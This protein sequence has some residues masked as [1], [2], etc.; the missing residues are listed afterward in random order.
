MRKSTPSRNHVDHDAVAAI[1]QLRPYLFSIAYRMAGSASEA[2]DIVQEAFLRYYSGQP[3]TVESPKAYLGTVVTRLALDHL[4]S[5]RVTKEQY[6]GPWLPEPV[7]TADLSPGPESQAESRDDISMAFL[8]LLEKL[9][10]EERA[11]FVLREAFDFQYDD[12][13]SVL[14][15]SNAATRK[16]VQRARDRVRRKEQ[17]HTSSYAE[18][19][20]L[21]ERFLEAARDGNI[22]MF[23]DVLAEDVTIWAD[24]GE[25]ALAARK[26]VV[27]RENISRYS[28]GLIHRVF[29]D[30]DV[31]IE[32]VNG[33]AGLLMWSGG[34]LV[35]ATTVTI[36]DGRIVALHAVI[37]PRKLAHLQH[38][39]SR[40]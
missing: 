27:G 40:P 15:K 5:A 2:E 24:G 34:T 21:A 17:R 14:G 1:E 35:S 9:S 37:N 32:S 7:L 39:L 25:D 28:T 11:A 20:R 12:I 36:E 22:Q 19:R 38:R 8:V 10:P 26:P 16:L 4:K 30:A 6:R 13:A 23:T 3:E 33:Q 18:Q 29:P 31:T